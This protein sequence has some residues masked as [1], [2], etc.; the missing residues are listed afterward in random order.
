MMA[1]A[2]WDG[3]SLDVASCFTGLRVLQR[4]ASCPDGKLHGAE[5]LNALL[6][7]GAK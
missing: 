1:R 5:L 4:A 6:S 3:C 2:A 7:H